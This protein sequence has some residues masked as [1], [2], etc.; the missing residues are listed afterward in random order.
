MEPARGVSAPVVAQ[1]AADAVRRLVDV[2]ASGRGA[3][4]LAFP[5]DVYLALGFL[6]RATREMPSA[7]EQLG[8]WLLAETLAGRV[9]ESA[10]G[11]F[12]GDARQ[13]VEVAAEALDQAVAACSQ[14]AEA[15][16]HAQMALRAVQQT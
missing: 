8:Q 10:A 15:L 2:T 7:I 13:A 9:A 1:R 14:A 11:P 6:A 3:S 12:G 5:G 16:T 4:G